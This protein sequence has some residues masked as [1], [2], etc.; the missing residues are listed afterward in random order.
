MPELFGDRYTRAGRVGGLP[1]RL[2]GYGE[3]WDGDE[4]VLWAE[5]EVAQSAVF[6]EGGPRRARPATR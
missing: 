2:A 3:R 4:C 6:G 5:G 1:A